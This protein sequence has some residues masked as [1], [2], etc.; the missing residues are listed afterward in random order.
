MAIKL[1]SQ[2]T[3]DRQLNTFQ[4][5]LASALQPITMNPIAACT[6]ITKVTLTSG[7]INVIPVGLPQALQG[8]F[9]V[10]S[11]ANAL[12]WD[13]QDTNTT[14]SQNLL[15]NTTADTVVDIAIF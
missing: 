2:Q 11:R 6:I 7:K 4:T 14:P 5:A 1:P 12:V 8:W 13:S 3:N 9:L 10:R 15:L